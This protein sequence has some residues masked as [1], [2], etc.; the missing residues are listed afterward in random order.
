MKYVTSERRRELLGD[1]IIA[2]IHREVALAPPPPPE[3]IARLRLILAP[4][5]V[6]RGPTPR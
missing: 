6:T 5:Y 3:L 1:E 2:H 4:G